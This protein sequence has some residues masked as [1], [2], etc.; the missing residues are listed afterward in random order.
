MQ[1]DDRVLTYVENKP[2]QQCHIQIY[3]SCK[4]PVYRQ[5]KF[6]IWDHFQDQ[7]VDQVMY[8]IWDQ[9]LDEY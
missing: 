1:I 4:Y 8:H 6:H 7:I 3:E 2:Q 9:L 5:A